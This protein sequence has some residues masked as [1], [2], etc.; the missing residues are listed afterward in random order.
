MEN[1]PLSLTEIES[2]PVQYVRAVNDTLNALRGKWKLPIITALLHESKRFGDLQ[3]ALPRIMPRLLAKELRELELNSIVE[4]RVHDT[5]PVLIEYQLTPSAYRLKQVL[6]KMITWGI[7]HQA[8]VFGTPTE[9]KV[10]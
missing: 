1:K 9:Q 2:C 6:D 8:Y 7:A 4:R 5:I 10:V 3:R